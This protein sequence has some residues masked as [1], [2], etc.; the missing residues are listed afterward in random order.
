MSDPVDSLP[1]QALPER[2]PPSLAELRGKANESLA[3]LRYLI[4]WLVLVAPGS[5]A[6]GS[7][8]ALFLWSLER[9][10]SIR[11]E[12]PW[13]LWLLPMAGL[14]VGALYHFLG[15]SAEGGNNLIMD[16]IH[17][18][19]GGVPGRMA[20]LV[21]V[22]TVITHLFG[23]SAGR[24]GTAIQMGGSI[25]STLARRFRLDPEDASILLTTGMAAGFGAVFGTPLTGAVFALEVLAIGRVSYRA[26]VPCLF[27][28]VIGDFTVSAWGIHHTT[29]AIAPLA[30][31]GWAHVDPI[32]L[33]KVAVAAVAFGLVSTVFADATHGI[34]RLFKRYVRWPVARPVIGGL[35]VIALVC[36]LGTR[37][38][39]GL[40]V[41]SPDAHAVT[42]LS[43]FHAGGATTWS[44]LWKL[45]F[46][47]VTLGAGFKGGEVTPLFF[48]G[49]AL[50]NALAIVLHAPVDLFAGLGFIAVFAGA[51]NT[52][53]ACTLMGIELFGAD[54]ALYL[55]A[56]SFL[57]YLFS[58][59]SGIYS[60]QRIATPKADVAL[61]PRPVLSLATLREHRRQA[62]HSAR[63][64][65]FTS[66]NAR[67]AAASFTLHVIGEPL[68]SHRH[69]HHH[70]TPHTASL[71]HVAHHPHAEHIVRRHAPITAAA[72]GQ[73]RVYT[74]ARDRR[75][76]KGMFGRLFGA[77]IADALITEAKRYGL[78]HAL[79]LN[80]RMGYTGGG[81]IATDHPEHGIDKLPIC[82]E[83]MA[84]P[85]MLE[86]F[87][88][89]HADLL[90]GRMVVF[91]H[92]ET[93]ELAVAPIA[94]PEGEVAS[95]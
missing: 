21:L 54:A 37:D 90:L 66:A 93:W 28:S 4:R 1:V 26:L 91:R 89:D 53:L 85:R 2:T 18:P 73:V 35:V 51:T 57:A 58:G 7:A 87:C 80:T 63:G 52:P 11:F 41:S 75:P 31:G 47:A 70:V 92:A 88:C 69:T 84:E 44:W 74:T 20:P 72:L 68:V 83:L 71:A 59:H 64:M 29:Y 33:A 43:S 14:A 46:T 8:V 6:I 36:A 9:A 24:E 49:A 95:A 40:G 67:D 17:E 94:E 25:A 77:S 32:L 10:T 5:V 48:V 62:R 82:V 13:L 30:R 16:E 45:L 3:S 38:Y 42:I 15:K 39:L 76:G 65:S 34:S 79:V 60:S 86:A 61:P 50:G 12:S 23:G 22:S 19:G 27:A 81:P 78:P 55:A 56:A